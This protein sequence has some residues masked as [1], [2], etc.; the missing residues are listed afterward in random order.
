MMM[1]VLFAEALIAGLLLLLI[2]IEPVTRRCR[3]RL[4]RHEAYQEQQG[5]S[6]G[7][8]VADVPK[9]EE[10]GA[11]QSEQPPQETVGPPTSAL[12]V[13]QGILGLLCFP[14]VP[15]FLF[16]NARI[17]AETFEVLL[18]R[19]GLVVAELQVFHISTQLTDLHL[20]G[21]ALGIAQLLLGAAAA[22]TWEARSPVRWV[23]LA[24][25][26][27]P[28]LG[29]EVVLAALR[30]YLLA[31]ADG[32]AGLHPAIQAA[33]SGAQA[34]ICAFGELA[35]AY[36]TVHS[37]GVPLLQAALALISAPFR[38][39]GRAC[40]ALK[41]ARDKRPKPSRKNVSGPGVVTRAGAYLDEA[42]LQRLRTIDAAAAAVLRRALAARR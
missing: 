17:L 9:V 4:L 40:R 26:V 2:L 27:I 21:L 35:S 20:Y 41:E 7:P 37:F 15:V 34:Y 33:A 23:F 8:P 10:H 13:R 3:V 31:A 16:L 5:A 18:N 39:L 42:I 6:P 30:G 25:G 22:A 1:P 28:L 19:P 36:L 24:G 29:Y 32:G 12:A 14:L 38:F 11:S